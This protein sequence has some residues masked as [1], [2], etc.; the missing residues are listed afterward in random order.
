[1]FQ[2]GHELELNDVEFDD[3]PVVDEAATVDVD[4]AAAADVVEAFDG[5]VKL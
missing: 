2:D 3:G 1:M 4:E 5:S